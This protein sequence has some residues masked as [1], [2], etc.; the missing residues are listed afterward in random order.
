MNYNLSQFIDPIKALPLK[1]KYTK[2]ELL[3]PDFFN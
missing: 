3:T 1:E 2:E